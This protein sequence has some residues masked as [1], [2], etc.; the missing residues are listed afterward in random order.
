[1]KTTI[2]QI[3]DAIQTL[4]WVRRDA[5][6]GTRE[7]NK[8]TNLPLALGSHIARVTA[9]VIQSRFTRG[10]ESRTDS[11]DAAATVLARWEANQ[12]A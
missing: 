7:E 2:A 12:S 1:M 5:T 10:I 8:R 6:G 3:R 11:L 4:N 9:L